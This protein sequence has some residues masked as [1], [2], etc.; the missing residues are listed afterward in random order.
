MPPHLPFAEK[1]RDLL[2]PFARSC[3]LP[4]SKEA[5]DRRV[6]GRRRHGTV[7]ACILAEET[8]N[9]LPLRPAADIGAVIDQFFTLRNFRL[10]DGTVMPQATIAYETGVY[11]LIH[12]VPS[13]DS[14][15]DVA[16]TLPAHACSGALEMLNPQMNSRGAVKHRLRR[17]RVVEPTISPDSL[18]EGTGFELLVRGRSEAGC[19]AP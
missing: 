1:G 16:T 15:N 10:T 11:L 4:M 8:M 3:R 18:L 6:T 5:L 7:D 12:I 2:H 13:P 17:A 9:D 14:D 19:R